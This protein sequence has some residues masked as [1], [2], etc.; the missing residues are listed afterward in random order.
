MN[1]TH[2]AFL[3]LLGLSLTL[4]FANYVIDLGNY[5]TLFYYCA[6]F[7]LVISCLDHASLLRLVQRRE[8]A[9]LLCG[10]LLLLLLGLLPLPDNG[11]T[12]RYLQNIVYFA[13]LTLAAL[14]LIEQLPA[15]IRRAMPALFSLLFCAGLVYQLAGLL[16]VN[17]LTA[18]YWNQ[19]F[20]AQFCLI[21]LPVLSF[22][23]L[24]HPTAISVALWLPFT[25]IALLLLVVTQSRPGWI[26]LLISLGLLATLYLRGRSRGLILGA[27]VIGM[28][29]TYLLLPE[30]VAAS[31]DDLIENIGQEERVTIWRDGLRMQLD[32]DPLYWL[33]GH[34]PGSYKGHFASFNTYQD[35]IYFPHN[36][37]L[38][39]LFESGIIGLTLVC[40]MYGG[41]FKIAHPMVRNDSKDRPLML[42][43]LWILLAQLLFCFLTLPFYSKHVTLLQAPIVAGIFYLHAKSKQSTTR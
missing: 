43:L 10:A 36:Y 26:A 18:H 23:L 32:A 41:L 17:S 5:K 14:T 20:L 38:E 33:F 34:G 16:T 13:I 35:A 8:V 24:R 28:S 22:C 7:L 15:G 37:V 25:A 2:R 9:L 6:F 31:V 27:L 30:L 11:A 4:F 3:S 21:A 1:Y 12:R 40:A 29:A 42:T 39:L 19:H